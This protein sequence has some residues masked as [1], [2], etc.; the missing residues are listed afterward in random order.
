[1][2]SNSAGKGKAPSRQ[3]HPRKII[4]CYYPDN[5]VVFGGGINQLKGMI[6]CLGD[7]QKSKKYAFKLIIKGYMEPMNCSPLVCPSS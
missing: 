6:V 3:I 1:M 2:A 4:I 5:I 7:P